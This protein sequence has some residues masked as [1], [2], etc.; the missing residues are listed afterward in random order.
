M[1]SGDNKNPAP[2][3]AASSPPRHFFPSAALS[4]PPLP[5]PVI[6]VPGRPTAGR[7]GTLL[8]GRA[9][10][11][12]PAEGVACAV[13]PC[14]SGGNSQGHPNGVKAAAGSGARA[15]GS[16]TVHTSKHV[17]RTKLPLRD[18]SARGVPQT[19]SV[20][21]VPPLRRLVAPFLGG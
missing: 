2:L 3:P 17:Q 4:L 21:S 15:D 19:G 12:Q 18:D 14:H 1:Q 11:G 13:V 10:Q 20:D 9:W 16:T 6:P 7:R 5:P 8:D